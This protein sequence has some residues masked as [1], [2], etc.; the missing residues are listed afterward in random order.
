MIID[1]HAHYDDGAFDEDRS[2]LLSSMNAH[3]IEKIVNVCADMESLNRLGPLMEAYPFVYGAAGIHPDDAPLVNEAVLDKIRGMAALSKVVAIGEIGLDYYWHKEPEEHAR[4]QV[5][6]RAQMDLAR[7]V[8]LPFIIHSRE[9]AADTLQIVREYMAGG[10]MAGGILHCFSYSWE[11]ARQY[12]DMGLYLGIGGV[13]T[14]KNARKLVEV[15][16]KAPLSGLLLET[17]CPY[18][19]PVPHRGERNSSLYLPLVARRIAE[20]KGIT[21]EEVIRVTRENAVKLLKLS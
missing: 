15:V 6:F 5:V 7:D 2:S 12:L 13:V 17:D 21:A 19:P 10:G 16:E 9:A 1:T 11:M 14:Y 8:K 20:I 4:Q 3:G 18:L